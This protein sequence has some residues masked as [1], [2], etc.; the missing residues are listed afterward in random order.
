MSVDLDELALETAKEMGAT[1][2]DV[3]TD[4]IQGVETDGK[5]LFYNPY[6]MSRI[7]TAGGDDGL[8]FVV[9]HEL[10]HQVGGMDV[11]GHKGEFMADDY[12]ARALARAGGDVKGIS[13]VFSVITES[14]T[15]PSVR[16]RESRA[17]KAF[18][19]EPKGL[20][21]VTMHKP[22]GTKEVGDLAI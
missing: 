8:R 20:D 1:P 21:D 9:A 16:D 7:G 18:R 14:P 5:S 17:M 22:T 19:E 12:A 13:G 2:M 10:G 3:K 15:H 6:T 4:D 11:G